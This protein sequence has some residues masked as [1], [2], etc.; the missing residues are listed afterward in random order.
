MTSDERPL[1]RWAGSKR[2]QLA[3]IADY[4]PRQFSRY[5][6]PFCGSC[7]ALFE[8]GPA[9]AVMNDINPEL[10][11]FWSVIKQDPIEVHSRVAGMPNSVDLYYATR[12]QNPL[13]LSSLDRAVRFFYLNRYSFNGLY[14]TNREG[15]FNVPYGGRRCGSIPPVSAF[16]ACSRALTNVTLS[17]ED[18][19]PFLSRVA[20]RGD[21]VYLD[22]PYAVDGSRV[23]GEYDLQAFRLSDFARLTDELGRLDRIGAM[24]MLSYPINASSVSG[25]DRYYK[26][27]YVVRRRISGFRHGRSPQTEAVF[28]NYEVAS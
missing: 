13:E 11:N 20:S 10:M 8:V 15:R 21:F 25:M 23:S 4:W 1:L 17:C 2:L 19:Q 27:Q 18:F 12:S 9:S 14:R 5:I 16:V 3:A 6:E 22:P 24:F 28:T 26:G 7:A